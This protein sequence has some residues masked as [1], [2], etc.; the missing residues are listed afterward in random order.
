MS[1]KN[2][3]YGGSFCLGRVYLLI[4]F[5]GI[6]RDL[7]WRYT[8]KLFHQINPIKSPGGIA[9]YTKFSFE[10][11]TSFEELGPTGIH[12]FPSCKTDG[13]HEG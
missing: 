5:C 4:S 7:N 12:A 1:V 6:K 10:E 11:W 8:C 2:V 3:Q 9:I 13:R